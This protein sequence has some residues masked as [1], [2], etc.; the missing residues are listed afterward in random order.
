MINTKKGKL[1]PFW[2]LKPRWGIGLSYPRLERRGN[3]G[4]AIQGMNSGDVEFQYLYP[5]SK[6]IIHQLRRTLVR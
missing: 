2:G 6:V 4:R 1:S 5:E 3:S